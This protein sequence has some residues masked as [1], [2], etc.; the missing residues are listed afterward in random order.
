ME[1]ALLTT[2]ISTGGA[3]IVGCFGL[4]AH[5]NQTGKRIDDLRQAMNR[6]EDQFHAF[7]DL[8]NGKFAALDLEIARLQD[9]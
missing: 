5:A 3:V 6:L 2:L 4:W 1:S 8:V 7:K 9:K